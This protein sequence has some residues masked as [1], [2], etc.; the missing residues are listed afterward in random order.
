MTDEA[1]DHGDATFDV[2]EQR[3]DPLSCRGAWFR[4]APSGVLL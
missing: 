1:I 2:A 4:R 3:A